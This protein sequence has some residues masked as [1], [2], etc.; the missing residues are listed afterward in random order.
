MYLATLVYAAGLTGYGYRRQDAVIAY[1]E[2]L[3]AAGSNPDAIMTTLGTRGGLDPLGP[4]IIDGLLVADPVAAVL[5]VGVVVF[6]TVLFV[7]VRLT[8]ISPGW[9][10]TYLY[11]VLALGPITGVGYGIVTAPL[12]V[13]ELLLFLGAPLLTLG[14]L[15][16]YAKVRPRIVGLLS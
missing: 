13:V 10:P 16:G 2:G 14:A 3:V 6:P 12:I 1:V 5:A 15:L 11:V 7:L 9:K 4:T 8:R